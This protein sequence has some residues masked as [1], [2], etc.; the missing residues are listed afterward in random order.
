RTV[1]VQR[2]EVEGRSPAHE[3]PLPA[4]SSRG[5]MPAVPSREPGG[6]GGVD[7]PVDGVVGGALLDLGDGA[8]ARDPN[9]V[10]DPCELMRAVAVVVRISREHDALAWGVGC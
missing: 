2:D 10:L 7:R 3:V 4:T 9:R 6:V 1:R 5:A 8:L